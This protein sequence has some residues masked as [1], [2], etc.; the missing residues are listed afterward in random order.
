MAQTYNLIDEH[1]VQVLTNATPGQIRDY[2]G[3]LC[4][5][6]AYVT[7]G[8]KVAGHTIE[9]GLCYPDKNISEEEANFKNQFGPDLYDEWIR[10]TSWFKAY[11]ANRSN[12]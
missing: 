11:F 5:P 9:Y 2:T 8:Y 7:E 12:N 6:K 3:T 10:V 4:R 1:G